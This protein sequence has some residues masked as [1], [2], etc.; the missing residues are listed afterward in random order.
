MAEAEGK[1]ISLEHHEYNISP[2]KKGPKRPRFPEDGEDECSVYSFRG[3]KGG[4]GMTKWYF[5][6]AFVWLAVIGLAAY[7]VSTYVLKPAK[8]ESY[9]V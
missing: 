9:M 5:F 1:E 4:K 8:G 6:C 2:K 3:R 7:L